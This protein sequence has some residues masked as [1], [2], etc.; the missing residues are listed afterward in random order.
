M[1]LLSTLDIP[2]YRHLLLYDVLQM[3]EKWAEVKM[4]GL[5]QLTNSKC[6]APS[7][8]IVGVP[9]SLVRGIF[10]AMHE[11]GISL[12]NSVDDGALRAG[13]VVMTPEELKQIGGSEKIN[14][15]GKSFSYYL[16]GLK[17]VPAKSWP[18]VSTCWHMRIKSPEL[19][20]LR[21]SY[22]LPTKVEGDSDFSI[23][24]AVRKTGVLSANATSKSTKQQDSQD[25]PDWTL[26]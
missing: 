19:G 15:R 7:Y 20:K 22:G 14:E 1:S 11:P 23:V 24:V 17:E 6:A 26:P 5:L 25:L 3:S 13:I 2:D 21:R 4:T 12:P 8:L 18:G 9:T 16:A 10:D